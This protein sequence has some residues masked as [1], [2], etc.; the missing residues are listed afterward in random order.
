MKRCL[1]EFD[2]EKFHFSIFTKGHH[3]DNY[4]DGKEAHSFGNRNRV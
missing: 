2:L 4:E 3:G 1:A